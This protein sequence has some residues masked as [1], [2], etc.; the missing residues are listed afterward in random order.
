MYWFPPE[1]AS[2]FQSGFDIST[3]RL[4]MLGFDV[5]S[6]SQDSSLSKQEDSRY[7]FLELLKGPL[8]LAY[9]DKLLASEFV[10]ILHALQVVQFCH[11]KKEKEFETSEDVIKRVILQRPVSE[12]ERRKINCLK[13][14]LVKDVELADTLVGHVHTKRS[15]DSLRFSAM[16]C[17][18]ESYTVKLRKEMAMSLPYWTTQQSI[19]SVV[20]LE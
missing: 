7:K 11:W 14:E 12:I 15:F 2:R 16:V 10:N 19:F 13:V 18:W 1:E 6:S 4:N 17:E 5:F 3:A 8:Y 20:D 9:E